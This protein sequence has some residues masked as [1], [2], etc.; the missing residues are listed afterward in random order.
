MVLFRLISKSM[1]S[2]DERVVRPDRSR[3]SVM[4]AP[5]GVLIVGREQ[6]P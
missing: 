4:D 5:V 6:A 2:D 1:A 3:R